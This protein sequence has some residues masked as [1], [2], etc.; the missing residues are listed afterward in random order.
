MFLRISD[1]T[2]NHS[3]CQVSYESSDTVPS[4]GDA[5]LAIL[6]S[7]RLYG[8]VR[9]ATFNST[10]SGAIQVVE[11]VSGSGSTATTTSMLTQQSGSGFYVSYLG[12]V[13]SGLQS[14]IG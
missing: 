5:V 1:P 11:V 10:G 13:G 6:R 3:S 4:S 12:P 9:E 8:E 2:K 7:K 14:R